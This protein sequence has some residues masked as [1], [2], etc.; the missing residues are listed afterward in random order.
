[1]RMRL[2]YDEARRQVSD[3]QQQLASIEEQMIPGQNESD[4]DRSEC[5][6]HK[7][8]GSEFGRDLLSKTKYV[9]RPTYNFDGDVWTVLFLCQI[10][11]DPR[12]GAVIARTAWGQC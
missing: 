2:Q 10:V 7:K 4:K 11:A 6:L 8:P 1:M 9:F 3:L 5:G 12:E